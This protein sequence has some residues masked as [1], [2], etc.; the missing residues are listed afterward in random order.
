MTVVPARKP[1][2]PPAVVHVPAG[3]SNGDTVLW[4]VPV[5]VTV[6]PSPA[7]SWTGLH[8]ATAS[9]NSPYTRMLFGD[10]CADGFTVRCGYWWVASGPVVPGIAATRHA[11]SSSVGV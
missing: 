10:V 2:S 3:S 11:G 4:N 9:R 7:Y 6:P 1:W 8:M 5:A